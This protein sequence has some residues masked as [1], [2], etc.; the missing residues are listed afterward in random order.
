MLPIKPAERPSE[1]RR[2]RCGP[3]VVFCHTILPS[4]QQSLPALPLYDP[5]YPSAMTTCVSHATNMLL[6]MSNAEPQPPPALSAPLASRT[7]WQAMTLRCS[8]CRCL[9][10][11]LATSTE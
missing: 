11:C 7:T 5:E 10:G 6:N 9:L 8:C 1:E 2:V 4:E 3:V